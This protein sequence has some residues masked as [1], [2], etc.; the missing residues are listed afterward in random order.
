MSGL[1]QHAPCPFVAGTG[2]WP[3]SSPGTTEAFTRCQTDIGH[4][5]PGVIETLEIAQFGHHTGGDQQLD[6]P[7]RLHRFDQ[8][9]EAPSAH[10]VGEF[11]VEPFQALVAFHN[12]VEH[13]PEHRV[14]C[15]GGHHQFREPADV[16]GRPVGG[17]GVPDI[18]PQQERLELALGILEIPHG[19]LPGPGEIADG[20]IFRLWHIDGI[21]IAVAQQLSQLHAVAFVGFDLLPGL[22]RNQ[23][24]CHH[25]AGIT[26]VG[27]QPIE[28]VTARAGFINELKLTLGIAGFKLPHHFAD[29]VVLGTDGT[30]VS[31]RFCS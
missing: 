21:D 15:R 16:R 4:Q 14:L 6:A 12:G 24:R 3:D 26:P 25:K 11:V 30:Q 22:F 5:L 9:I 17:A 27:Q 20:L 10:L 1:D 29:G 8:G 2:Q 7:E 18:V 19:G 31:D 23:R 13:F 28:P